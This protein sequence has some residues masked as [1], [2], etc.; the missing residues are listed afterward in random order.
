MTESARI[1]AELDRQAMRDRAELP[2][3]HDG[4]NASVLAT[5]EEI[6]AERVRKEKLYKSLGESQ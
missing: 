3:A 4:Y 6:E 5:K 1:A 2:A